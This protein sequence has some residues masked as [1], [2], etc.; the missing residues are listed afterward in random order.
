MSIFRFKNILLQGF[1]NKL[2]DFTEKKQHF[3]WK[4][5]NLQLHYFFFVL[6]QFKTFKKSQ[7]K[8]QCPLI[9]KYPKLSGNPCL[10]AKTAT[11]SRANSL[12]SLLTQAFSPT[13][14]LMSS[15]ATAAHPG[16]RWVSQTS[17]SITLCC[18]AVLCLG[19][20]SLTSCISWPHTEK[21]LGNHSSNCQKDRTA[22][23]L[24]HPYPLYSCHL[25][26]YL[27]CC[28]SSATW[29]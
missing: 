21:L 12:P 20:L 19:N 2:K 16:W 7:L 26:L 6:L 23:V 28:Y 11:T 27:H 15:S 10:L 14:A 13:K 17:A 9:Q 18:A 25:P 1:A 22:L 4:H 5:Q 3:K 24:I 8:Q 29:S